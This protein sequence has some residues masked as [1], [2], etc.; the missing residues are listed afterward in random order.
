MTVAERA[1]EQGTLVKGSIDDIC[2]CRDQIMSK[3]PFG[4]TVE[5]VEVGIKIKSRAEDHR[6]KQLRVLVIVEVRS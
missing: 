5:R 6:R 2:G 3:K 4:K 1:E